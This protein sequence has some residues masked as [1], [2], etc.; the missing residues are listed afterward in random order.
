MI[1]FKYTFLSFQVE[2]TRRCNLACPHCLRGDAQQ[3]VMSRDII[4]NLLDKT[5]VFGSLQF[6][7]GEPFVDFRTME[8]FL[9]GVIDRDIPVNSVTIITNGTLLDGSCV[10]VLKRLHAHIKKKYEEGYKKPMPDEFI[11]SKIN[12]SISAD[13]YHCT[14]TDALYD[15]AEMLFKDYATIQ[16]YDKGNEVRAIG[17]G[18]N[19][20][21]ALKT[22]ESY[23]AKIQVLGRGRK[24]ICPVIS[25]ELSDRTDI[26]SYLICCN[27]YLS[28]TGK[29]LKSDDFDFSFEDNRTDYH[30]ADL[31]DNTKTLIE[32]IDA[33]NENKPLCETFTPDSEELVTDYSSALQFQKR[34]SEN[35]KHQ[36]DERYLDGSKRLPDQYKYYEYQGENV[37]EREQDYTAVNVNRPNGAVI[38]DIWFPGD[39]EKQNIKSVYEYLDKT[40]VIAFQKYPEEQKRYLRI[41][42][43]RRKT[44]AELKEFIAMRQRYFKVMDEID[45]LLKSG[46]S[47]DEVYDLYTNYTENIINNEVVKKEDLLKIVSSSADRDSWSI[48]KSFFF[49]K[50]RQALLGLNLDSLADMNPENVKLIFAEYIALYDVFDGLIKEKYSAEYQRD[51]DSKDQTID[52]IVGSRKIVKKIADIM[53]NDGKYSSVNALIKSSALSLIGMIRKMNGGV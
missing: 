2:I 4:D 25:K 21:Y 48:V 30:I 34:R 23:L 43:G 20:P 50:V 6:T 24:P 38:A 33:Y 28:A 9:D 3:I 47:L 52:V 39:I 15:N 51:L 42:N 10:G 18:V 29:L 1:D 16:L 49:L 26:D 45:K 13:D 37:A 5:K 41:V 44:E 46:K 36:E 7:G 8:Y 32:Q 12:I 17:R 35:K 22:K 19:I 14:N 31:A 40:E 11:A 53:M 27:L